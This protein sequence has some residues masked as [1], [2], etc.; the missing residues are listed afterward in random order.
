MQYAPWDN[1]GMQLYTWYYSHI[2][3]FNFIQIF[4]IIQTLIKI[5]STKQF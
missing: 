4:Y 1:E 3:K 5:C 2:D